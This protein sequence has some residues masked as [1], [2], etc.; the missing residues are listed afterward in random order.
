MS[1]FNAARKLDIWTVDMTHKKFERKNQRSLLHY[2][3][4]QPGA[5]ESYE[6]VSAIFPEN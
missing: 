1:T 4:I 5:L 3:I 2:T 6:L